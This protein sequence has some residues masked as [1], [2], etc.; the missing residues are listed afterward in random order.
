MGMIPTNEWQ[1]G[2]QMCRAYDV[3]FRTCENNCIEWGVFSNSTKSSGT[4]HMWQEQAIQ[5]CQCFIFLLSWHSSFLRCN[6]N[7][8]KYR[9]LWYPWLSLLSS[10]H[11][12]YL[13]C[14]CHCL[15]IW[16]YIL[17]IPEGLS[18]LS[19][20][21]EFTSSSCKTTNISMSQKLSTMS[22]NVFSLLSIPQRLSAANFCV[23]LGDSFSLSLSLAGMDP[24]FPIS[25]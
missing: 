8:D 24:I 1:Y 2:L 9:R 14:H 13:S 12:H 21:L 17:K 7:L 22:P 6:M 11:L 19:L 18:N 3:F 4:P 23:D 5:R 16:H 10:R 25:C 20:L 15:V